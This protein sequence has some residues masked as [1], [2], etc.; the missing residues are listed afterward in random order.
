MFPKN[1]KN[2]KIVEEDEDEI[3][4]TREYQVISNAL[5]QDA[6]EFNTKI[7]EQI[8]ILNKF[9]LQTNEITNLKISIKEEEEDRLKRTDQPKSNYEQLPKENAQIMFAAAAA[10]SAPDDDGDDKKNASA[11]LL[12]PKTNSVLKGLQYDGEINVNEIKQVEIYYEKIKNKKFK[13]D[14][15]TGILHEIKGNE[16]N[17][18]Q[19]LGVWS[20]ISGSIL[21]GRAFLPLLGGGLKSVISSIFGQEG[22]MYEFSDKLSQGIPFS[23][24]ETIG[25]IS[26][27][28]A[29]IN[30]YFF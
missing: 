16:K 19:Y 10:S 28:N 12:I 4:N 15:D 9:R 20:S 23:N 26:G 30:I 2:K 29:Y 25:G 13:M 24:S 22:S 17:R 3:E 27:I 1:T 8:T 18:F 6:S 14:Y 11:D 7:E 21:V 5:G